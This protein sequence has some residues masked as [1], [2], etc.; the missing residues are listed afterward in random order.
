MQLLQD[1][2][3][4]FSQE[5]IVW[6]F[7]LYL[8]LINFLA[9]IAMW[10][11]KRMATNDGWRISEATLHLMSFCGGAFGVTIGI[12]GFRHKTRKISFQAITLIAFI[13]SVIL[14]WIEYRAIIWHLYFI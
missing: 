4:W 9:I 11:D 1:I 12:F 8:I 14:Y 10:W 7:G 3:I 2:I 5:P 13:V 6:I